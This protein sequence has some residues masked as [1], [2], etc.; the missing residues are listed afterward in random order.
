MK[1][2][3][4]P[5]PDL[6]RTTQISCSYELRHKCQI[7]NAKK[8]IIYLKSLVC[9]SFLSASSLKVNILEVNDKS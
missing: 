9:M 6:I 5:A 3:I 4:M 2:T 1:F 8:N 7:Y